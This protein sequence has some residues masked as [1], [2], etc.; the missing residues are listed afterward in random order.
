MI[1][2]PTEAEPVKVVCGDCLDVLR[3]LPDG[4]VDVVITDPPYAEK[5]H[6]GA[7]GARPGVSLTTVPIVS[8]ASIDDAAFLHLC[9]ESV[10]V[11]LR[12]VLMTCDWRHSAAAFCCSTVGSTVVRCGVWL[13][14]DAAPQ[15]TGDRPGTGWEAVLILHRKGRKRWNGG[16]HHATWIYEVE[17]GNIHPTQKPLA[18][19]RKWVRDF[20][21][22][23]ELILDPFGGSGTTAVAALHEGRRCLIIE[24]DAGYCDIIRERVAEAMGEGRGSFLAPVATTSLFDDLQEE[25]PR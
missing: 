6:A 22:P 25:V 7:R 24:K 10:R 13:K 19:V 4:C 14:P 11:A 9:G 16:G 2:L 20:T 15:F 1:Q 3:A 17:R 5:T 23:G 12:W 18:L 21:D 8:F